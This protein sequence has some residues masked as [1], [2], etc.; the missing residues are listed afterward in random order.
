MTGGP[1]RMRGVR[2]VIGVDG[3]GTGTR[4]VLL[5]VAGDDGA[6]SAD[7]L[8]VLARADGPPAVA[9]AEDPGAA[10]SATAEV[11]RAVAGLAGVDLPVDV[12]WAALAGAGRESARSAVEAELGRTGVARAFRVGTD[13]EAAFHDAFADGPGVLLV[14]G[15]GSIAWGRAEDGREDRVGGWGAHLGDEGSGYAIGRE[16]LR[17][18]MRAADGR[19]PDTRLHDVVL[20][21]LGLEAVEDLVRWIAGAQRSRVAAL[22]PLVAEAAA[23]GD[24]VA[25]E[26]VDGA[27][28]E[29]VRHVAALVEKLGPWKTAPS[30]ALAGGLL[31]LGRPLRK[32]LEAALTRDGAR[33]LERDIDPAMGAGRLACAVVT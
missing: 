1:D 10:A 22:A 6:P 12:L 13:V 11:C 5:E 9:G 15:T 14:A 24:G 16:A 20:R 32:P 2:R 8:T 19:D 28:G 4:A 27:V 17:R 7:D 31:H 21:Q 3:G 30:V 29:L 18:I 26:I 33:L 25:A 23:A